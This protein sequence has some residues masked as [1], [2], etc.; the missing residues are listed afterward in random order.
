MLGRRAERRSSGQRYHPLVREFLEA[1]LARE[2]GRGPV[3]DLHAAVAEWAEAFDW[4]TAAYHY[5]A[6]HRWV[7]LRR[8][9]DGSVESIVAAGAFSIAAE[10]IEQIPDDQRLSATVEIVRSRL[11]S[12]VGDVDEVMAHARMA[13]DLDPGSDQVINN[14]IASSYLAGELDVALELADRLA[15][16]AKS[17]L[18]RSVAA[19]ATVSIRSSLDYDLTAA[20]DVMEDLAQSSRD[21]GHPHFEGVSLLNAALMYRAQ[22][23]TAKILAAASQAIDALSSSSSGNELASATF[24]KAWGLAFQGDLPAARKLLLAA[25]V[26]LRNSSRAEFLTEYAEVE[27]QFGDAGLAAHLLSEGIGLQIPDSVA[28][29]AKLVRAQLCIRDRDYEG[30]SRELDDAWTNK[31]TASPGHVSHIYALRALVASLAHSEETGSLSSLAI[32]F[33]DR[34]QA[35]LWR[36]VASI[37][38]AAKTGQLGPVLVALPSHMTGAISIACELVLD[39]L[40]SLRDDGMRIVAE[41]ASIRPERWRPSIRRVL[42]ERSASRLAAARLLDTVGDQ[43]DIIRLREFA[44]E[45]GQVGSDRL[46]G[47][48]LARRLAP[49]AIVEDLGRVT[50]RLGSNEIGGGDVR[51]K[52]LATLCFL[53]TKPRFSASREEVMDAMWPDMDPTAALNSLNQTLY[54]LRRVF[55]PEYSEDTSAGY[56]HQASDIVWLDPILVE[57]RSAEC[58]ELVAEY[59]RTPSP[60]VVRRLSEAYVGRFALDFAYEDWANDFRESLHVGYLHV[61]ESSIREDMKSGHFQRGAEVARRALEMDPGLDALELSLVRLLKNSGAHSAAA[62]QYGRYAHHL[63]AE[64]GVDPPPLESI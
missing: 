46:L 13:M 30:A 50:I 34:Q 7:D 33:A 47:R 51:R 1:R 40:A 14:L 35:Y 18:M 64:L 39:H 6:C 31:P 44:R 16:E 49:R 53:L 37:S 27:S 48:T 4:Q 45:P 22:G 20:I 3:D 9:L 5:T 2:I 58:V 42:S 36:E 12:L 28:A 56:V 23:A 63:R 52:V 38:S 62:E 26:D 29:V 43:S 32:A 24:I 8:V 15:S 41:E 11:A 60:D 55:E 19:A 10:Y 57:S 21:S 59:S 61:V 17:P 25:G 54:F